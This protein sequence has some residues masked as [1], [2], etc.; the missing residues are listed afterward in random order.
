MDSAIVA[1]APV[2]PAGQVT[3]VTNFHVIPDAVN[4]DNAKMELVFVRE[5]GMDD[6]AL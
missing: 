4:M 5:V 3:N 2:N 1:D 6:I